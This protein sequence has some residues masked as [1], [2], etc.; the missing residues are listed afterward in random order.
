MIGVIPVPDFRAVLDR[1]PNP[2]MVLDRG[3]HYVWANQAYLRVT[4]SRLED[5]RGRHILDAFPNDPDD[6]ANERARQ[7]RESLERVVARGAP[8]TL[9]FI[10]YRVGGEERIWSATH[11]PIPD[12]RGEVAF[13]LQHTVDITE[14]HRLRST[15][16]EAGVLQRAQQVQ[17]ASW[18]VDAE[19]R[20]LRRLFQQAPG[21][22]AFLRGRDHVF[23]LANEAYLQ[24][25]GDRDIIG[26][27]VREALPE[28]ADQGFVHLLDRVF[29]SGEPFV[30]R[31]VGALLQ[32][33][34]GGPLEER[35]V[36]FVFQPIVDSRGAVAGIFIQGQDITE[37]RRLEELRER[38]LRQAE[39]ANRLKDEF[40]ATLSHE[41]RTPLNAMLGWVRMLR[42]QP[43]D[44]AQRQHALGIIER[45]AGVQ[46]RL[47]QD[48]LDVSSIVT[49]KLRL[50]VAPVDLSDVVAAAIE[51]VK[52]AADA[53][54]V[55]ITR[56]DEHPPSITGDAARLQQAAWNLLTNAVKFTPPGGRIDV[57]LA[58]TD[59]GT[60]L[61]I[62]DT[63]AGIAP[64]V[65]PV[66]F[67]RFRQGE[68]ADRTQGGL[69]LGLAIVKHVV[70]AH[71]GSVTASSEGIGHGA[72]FVVDLPRAPVSGASQQGK[73]VSSS[74]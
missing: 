18:L 19:R 40:L 67:E 62:R 27:P 47:V 4:G 34:S 10:P 5:L 31:G 42:T 72:T 66:I 33:Q 16:T 30:G 41:L 25:V 38:L 20:H 51:T 48:I 36:D 8:D 54:G 49:G 2:Y 45:N 70:E 61:T 26:K 50:S 69:G 55:T 23:E 35:V 39:E 15:Q 65:V 3:L 53:K 24:L 71:G 12:E 73:T 46:A 6:P 28:I 56:E 29:E 13:V 14:L 63:G 43:M 58:G 7:L 21:F 32:R 1:S 52:P 57:R 9:A 74:V 64:H 37:R 11:T 68:G 44:E 60:R 59:G 17:E 22:T